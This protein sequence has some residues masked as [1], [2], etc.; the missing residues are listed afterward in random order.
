[1]RIYAVEKEVADFNEIHSC[2]QCGQEFG[3]CDERVIEVYFVENRLNYPQEGAVFCS[4]ECAAKFYGAKVDEVE[5]V[6]ND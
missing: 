6:N 2:L 5:I 1:M 3:Q 4:E